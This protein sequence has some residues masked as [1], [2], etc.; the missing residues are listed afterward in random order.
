MDQ[1]L[2]TSY[3]EVGLFFIVIRD[4]GLLWGI[5][6]TDNS[7]T[8]GLLAV[9][10]V[11]LEDYFSPLEGSRK[12]RRR[13]SLLSLQKDKW[14]SIMRGLVLFLE[15]SQMSNWKAGVRLQGVN[16]EAECPSLE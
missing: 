2:T 5:S 12:R 8:F 7:D 1:E 6:S 9:L 13:K 16:W 10:V 4:G 14:S 11:Q 15:N 3:T